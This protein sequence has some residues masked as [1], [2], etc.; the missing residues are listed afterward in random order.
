MNINKRKN[1]YKK[2][3]KIQIEWYDHIELDHRKCDKDKNY[4]PVLFVTSGIYVKSDKMH[5]FIAHH[6]CEKDEEC[7][8]EMKISKRCPEFVITHWVM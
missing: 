8:D 7:S 4:P 5:R 1:L 6:Y 2:G 3:H